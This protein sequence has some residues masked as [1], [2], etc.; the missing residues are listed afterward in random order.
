VLAVTPY[1]DEQEAAAIANDSD[2]GLGG[3]VWTA[4][5]DR[6]AAFARKIRSGTV[7][8]NGYVN[9]PVAPF[10]GIKASGMGRELCPEGLQPFQLLKTIY[11]YQVND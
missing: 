9:D 2:Y 11:L 7:G 8:V 10:G 6:G 5:P 3:S 4:D 1:A